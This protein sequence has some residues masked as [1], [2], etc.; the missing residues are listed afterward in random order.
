VLSSVVKRA[1]VLTVAADCTQEECVLSGMGRS[2]CVLVRAARAVCESSRA[3]PEGKHVHQ[4]L[5]LLTHIS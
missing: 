3:L 2:G 5:C 4:I 1:R